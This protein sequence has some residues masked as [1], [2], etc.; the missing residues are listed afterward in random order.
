MRF[1]RLFIILF[2]ILT[3]VISVTQQEVLAKVEVAGDGVLPEKLPEWDIT[4][5]DYFAE[6]K[7]TYGKKRNYERAK[8]KYLL[9]HTSTTNDYKFNRNGLIYDGKQTS[10]H[11]QRKYRK[12]LREIET[13]EQFIN[14]IATKSSTS[15]RY[16]LALPDDG[17]AYH[18]AG[19]LKYE[20][21]RLENFMDEL[22]KDKTASKE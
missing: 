13:A 9:G 16:Y 4:E 5:S 7:R 10:L 12:R 14:E 20:L 17:K 22:M 8:I 6:L 21:K 11:L 3:P 1:F 2:L 19:I 15:G 18:T